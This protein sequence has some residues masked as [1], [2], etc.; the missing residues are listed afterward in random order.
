M[1]KQLLFNLTLLI[2]LPLFNIATISQT[3]VMNSQVNKDQ[4]LTAKQISISAISALAAKGDLEKLRK[5]LDEGLNSG[6]TVNEIKEVLVKLYAYCGFPRSL[7][8]INRLSRRY[9]SGA[10]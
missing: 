3:K 1:K 9:Y 7:Q 2:L 5:A 10:S 8:G 6:L 4:N